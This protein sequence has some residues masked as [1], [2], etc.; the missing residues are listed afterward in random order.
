M[1]CYRTM[2]EL[3]RF[4]VQPITCHA[5]NKDKTSGSFLYNFLYKNP[6]SGFFIAEQFAI[7]KI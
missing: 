4:G 1:F 5:W 3:F 2:T 6:V 7:K